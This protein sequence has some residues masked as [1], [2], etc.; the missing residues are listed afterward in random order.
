MRIERAAEILSSP[1]TVEVVY[2]N[3][4]VWID[5][6]DEGRHTA[7]IRLMETGNRIEVPVDELSESGRQADYTTLN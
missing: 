6:I 1:N 7:S 3:M 2:N 4:P 5:N